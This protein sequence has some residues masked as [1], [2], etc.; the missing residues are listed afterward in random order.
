MDITIITLIPENYNAQNRNT[1][2]EKSVSDNALFSLS[3]QFAAYE[4]T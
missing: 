2:W 1:D 4:F 3:T